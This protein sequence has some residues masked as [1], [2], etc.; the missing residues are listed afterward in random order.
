M[1]SD[2]LSPVTDSKTESLQNEDFQPSEKT[3][4]ETPELVSN[5]S[6]ASLLADTK[7]KPKCWQMS[8]VYANAVSSANLQI[9]ETD[10]PLSTCDGDIFNI[11]RMH[12]R[13]FSPRIPPAIWSVTEQRPFFSQ[14]PTALSM[15]CSTSHGKYF[16]LTRTKLPN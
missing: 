2:T 4:R 7:S 6:V 13:I 15:R 1:E 12:E 5:F 9:S 11:D 8:E 14:W 16:L 10:E 3:K